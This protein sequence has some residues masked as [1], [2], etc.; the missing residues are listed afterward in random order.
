[1]DYNVIS[2]GTFSIKDILMLAALL[3]VFSVG[4]SD[5]DDYREAWFAAELGE[6]MVV[7]LSMDGCV[8]CAKLEPKLKEQHPDLI[9]I[10]IAIDDPNDPNFKLSA[11]GRQMAL[12][13]QSGGISVPQVHIFNKIEGK[14][15]VKSFYGYEEKETIN[16][17][18]LS[19][20]PTKVRSL[21]QTLKNGLR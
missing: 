21:F 18:N 2:I 5:Y 16:T 3:L 13:S 19:L 11:K 17:P 12:K 10:D 7:M 20:T 9:K 6:P 8:P 15:T 1:M 4:Y 14:W